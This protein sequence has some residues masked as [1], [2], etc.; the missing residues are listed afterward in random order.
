MALRTT[1][2]LLAALIT[3]GS[4]A[5][6]GTVGPATF[7]FMLGKWTSESRW[8]QPDQTTV[9]RPSRH[10][11]Y[12]AFGGQ[13]MI[14]DNTQLTGDQYIYFG[15][16]IRIYDPQAKHWLCRWFNAATSSW[17]P[18]FTLAFKDGKMTG[19]TPGE[20]THGQYVDT[21]TFDPVSYER[22]EWRLMRQYKTL[23]K[24]MEIGAI[25]YQRV[26]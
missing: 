7:D 20:D 15:S 8:L 4:N 21:I 5:E 23:S 17:G 13:G 3:A 11:F 25:D 12:R 1:A 6:T 19:Q 2:V 10:H 14:D 24:P 18:D 16:A 22:V 26:R 9:T